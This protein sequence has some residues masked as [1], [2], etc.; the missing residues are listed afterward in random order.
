MTQNLEIRLDFESHLARVPPISI[1]YQ[2]YTLA[3]CELN[4][5]TL[6]GDD[7]LRLVLRKAEKEDHNIL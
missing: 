1:G 3:N 7:T 2:F 5:E 6:Q 4:R